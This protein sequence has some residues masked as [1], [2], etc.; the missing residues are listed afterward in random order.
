MKTPLIIPVFNLLSYTRQLVEWWL[1]NTP[2]NPVFL[3]DQRSTYEPLT[4][5]L[6]EIV[7]N[8]RVFVIYNESNQPRENL[9]VFL[10][11]A[12]LQDAQYYCISDPD[13]MPCADT[14]PD[15]LEVF[16]HCIDK[17]NF[18]HVGFCLKIDDLPDY[19]ENK[20]GG[21]RLQKSWILETE[22]PAWQRPLSVR[23]KDRII[24]G[25]HWPIDTTF[26]MYRRKAGWHTPME[27]YAWSNALRILNARHQ[28]WYL[29]STELSDELRFYFSACAK[30][31]PGA[32]SLANSYRPKDYV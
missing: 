14:P 9:A 20:G 28:P 1:T 32:S 22:Q 12:W 27:G 15:F 23:F 31:A 4:A 19:E 25:Y 10:S 24:T 5:W 11:S 7:K 21:C 17:N 16:Q 13:I 18:H 6:R 29:K 26:A 2:D 8:P 3:L 30:A